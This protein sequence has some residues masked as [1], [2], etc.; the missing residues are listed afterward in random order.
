MNM[1]KMQRRWAWFLVLFLAAC[2]ATERDSGY[3]FNE[4][5]LAYVREGESTHED[6]LRALGTPSATSSFEVE[7][8]H[9]IGKKSEIKGVLEPEVKEQTV[10]SIEFD[11]DGIVQK[12]EKR[13]VADGQ[14][15]DIVGRKTGTEGHSVG[16]LE[17]LLGNFGKFNR[18]RGVTTRRGGGGY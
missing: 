5:S 9:Y 14:E 2:V 16:V 3:V 17:Q 6:V 1:R 10:L 8:W 12:V 18:E 4:S 7:R 11:E 15:V 13:S